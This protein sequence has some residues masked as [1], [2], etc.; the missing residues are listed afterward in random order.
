MLTTSGLERKDGYTKP[1]SER[2]GE[3]ER[4]RTRERERV[5]V[6]VREIEIDNRLGWQTARLASVATGAA[7]C[8]YRG[9]QITCASPETRRANWAVACSL[10]T[11]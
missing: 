10:Q 3:N 2:E 11:V 7:D 5:G 6:C 1:K 8:E 4:V 9:A